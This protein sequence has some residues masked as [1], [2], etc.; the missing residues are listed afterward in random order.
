MIFSLSMSIPDDK[1]KQKNGD[2]II[3][4]AKDDDDDDVELDFFLF[5]SL[6]T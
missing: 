6:S 4:N 5:S 1:S 2:I 3:D